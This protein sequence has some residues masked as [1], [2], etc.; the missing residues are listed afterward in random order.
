MW[1]NIYIYVATPIIKIYHIFF[2]LKNS[3]VPLPYQASSEAPGNNWFIIC[4]ERL[5]L[6]CLEIHVSQI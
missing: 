4:H 6:Y 3:L 1:A 2:T 5:D